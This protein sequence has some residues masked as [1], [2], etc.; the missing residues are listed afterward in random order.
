M[1]TTPVKTVQGRNFGGHIDDKP[2][3][4]AK[5]QLPDPVLIAIFEVKSQDPSFVS[6]RNAWVSARMES[7]A[8][9]ESQLYAAAEKEN[10]EL[11]TRHE[12]IKRQGKEQQAR[13]AKLR[14]EITDAENEFRRLNEVTAKAVGELHIAQK[15]RQE[16]SR[17]ASADEVQSLEEKIEKATA[18]VDAA[19][20]AAGEH[21]SRRNY[22]AM[23]GLKP[24]MEKMEELAI[25]EARL[26]A[27]IL[28]EAYWDP[29]FGIQIPAGS[30]GF[31][32]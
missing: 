19:E 5:P 6:W 2:S 18:K 13:I 15:E 7:N 32:K 24:L 12:D 1:F 20:K 21:L 27:R 9:A 29:E 31:S 25:E 8:E 4:D 17:Y 23:V 14:N 22:L 16:I 26:R 28:G 11:V 10:S 3:D 30:E